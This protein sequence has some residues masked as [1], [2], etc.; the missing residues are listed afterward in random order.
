MA[1]VRCARCKTLMP[2]DPGGHEVH[3][4][5][6]ILRSE[7]HGKKHVDVAY[8]YLCPEC[9]YTFVS[10]QTEIPLPKTVTPEEQKS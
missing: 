3:E 1:D 7:K 2:R 10:K 4:G 9:T 6:V 8:H 5:W